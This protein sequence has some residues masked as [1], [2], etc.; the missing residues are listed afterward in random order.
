MCINKKV[1]LITGGANGIGKEIAITLLEKNYTTLVF[2][3]N[4]QKLADLKIEF[5]NINTFTCDV[6]DY[7]KVETRINEVFDLF[8]KIEILINNAG[9]IHNEPLVKL[10]SNGIQKHSLENWNKVISV[11]LDSVFNMTSNVVE[12]M[13]LKR[14][15]GLIINISSISANGNAG[16]TVYSAT[17]A[18]VNALTFTWA[19]ELGIMGIRV[20]SISPGFIDINSTHISLE[21]EKKKEIIKKIPLRRL[22]KL[23]NIV[24]TVLFSIENDYFTGKV[25]EIDGGIEL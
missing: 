19:K 10:S 9:I 12:K 3:I 20:I 5:P 7:K 23:K 15:K 13:I 4:E 11:N 14:T 18:A 25:I 2:D 6:S 8:G 17:K 22:G 16:Q 24:E 21:E 1:V